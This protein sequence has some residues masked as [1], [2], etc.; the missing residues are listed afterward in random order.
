MTF[1]STIIIFKQRFAYVSRNDFDIKDFTLLS[2]LIYLY[3]RIVRIEFIGA[4]ASPAE[5]WFGWGRVGYPKM[6]FIGACLLILLTRFLQLAG[7]LF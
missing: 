7:V 3:S 1:L 4:M 6:Q 2:Y 5:V